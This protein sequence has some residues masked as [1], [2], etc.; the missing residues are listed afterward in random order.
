MCGRYTLTVDKDQLSEHF[1]CPVIVP[2]YRPRYNAA[3]SQLMPVVWDER[4]Q[5]NL[6]MM[7]WGLVPHWAKDPALGNKLINARAETLAEKPAFRDSFQRRRCIIPADG[8]YE[9]MKL[10]Q[11]KQP[12]RIVLKSQEPFG[13]AGLWD[14]WTDAEGH[15]LSSFTVI[16][17]AAAG[18]VRHIHNRMPLILN[19][20]DEADWLHSELKSLTEATS[21]L[22][23]LKPSEHL[24]AYP[25]DPMVNSPVH[26]RPEL[27]MPVND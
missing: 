5:T 18:P 20:A 13:M 22:A 19:R 7:K 9:W 14:R 27:I 16:T 6:T 26:D 21:F 3:P 12:M 23:Q 25:V 1:G 15:V 10:G 4:G 11:I 2:D 17:T 8:Y 24:K